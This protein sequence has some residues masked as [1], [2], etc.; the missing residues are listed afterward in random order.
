MFK[1]PWFVFCRITSF[2]IFGGLLSHRKLKIKL[3]NNIILI[4][5]ILDEGNKLKTYDE[6]KNKLN[7]K[8]NFLKYFSLIS[9]IK[10]K[11][12][13]NIAVSNHLWQDINYRRRHW[14]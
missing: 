9:M 12:V 7:C 3:D 2:F 6:L 11:N 10:S 8:L 5:D 14:N 4:K 1:P 13:T